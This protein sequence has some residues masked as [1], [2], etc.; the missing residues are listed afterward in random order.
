MDPSGVKRYSPGC[1][2]FGTSTRKTPR[3]YTLSFLRKHV[4]NNVASVRKSLSKLD[5][6]AI[7]QNFQQRRKSTDACAGQF[8][9]LEGTPSPLTLL[10]RQPRRKT[11]GKK[12]QKSLPSLSKAY[13]IKSCVLSTYIIF[14][15][16]FSKPFRTIDLR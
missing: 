7:R 11:T 4:R 3:V 1:S 2:F 6:M 10:D 8:R 14:C 9:R 15:L 16:T 12:R 5:M 13:F